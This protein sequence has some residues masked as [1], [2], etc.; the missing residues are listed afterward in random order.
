MG[1]IR[2]AILS[3]WRKKTKTSLFLITI[4]V[5]A[6]FEFAIGST[7]NA[8]I[9]IQNSAQAASQRSFRIEVNLTD[10]KQRLMDI[11]VTKLPNGATLSKMPNNQFG[12]VLME[13]VQRIAEVE[14]IQSY[15]ITTATFA[16]N[17][18]NFKRIEDSEND[19]Y[20]DQQAVTLRGNLNMEK[21]KD[22]SNGNLKLKEGRWG[23]EKDSNV[24]VISEEIAQINNLS[25]GDKIQ[26]NDYKD[27]DNSNVYTAEIIGI[28]LNAKSIEALMPGDTYRGENMIFTDLGF[29]EKVNQTPGDPLYQYATFYT[30]SGQD[31]NQVKRNIEKLNINWKRYDLI[32]DSGAVKQLSE[33]FGNI[34][35][36]GNLLFAICTVAG[37]IIVFLNFL[38]WVKQRQKEIGILISLGKSKLEIIGQFLTEAILISCIAFFI[39]IFISPIVAEKMTN[40]IVM[41]QNDQKRESD[42]VMAEQSEGP[43]NSDEISEELGAVDVQVTPI[44]FV[45]NFLQ[46]FI[47]IIGAIVL[48]SFT[49][50]KKQP[51]DI[52]YAR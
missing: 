50:M 52:L 37:I 6:C 32:D 3:V 29:P 22:V 15:N 11:P 21:D 45:K 44:M 23:N 41:E 35:Q 14:G 20:N 30:E 26:F 16:V 47:I 10:Y 1:L 46:I 25:V 17:P 42:Q 40:Y 18:Y 19:Q 27:R 33:N 48:M 13:D 12:S 43:T 5:I 39:S 7:Q 9:V 34:S 51:K 4:V 28:Y 8:Q 31:Y 24:C 36:I 38:F 2:R 49:I